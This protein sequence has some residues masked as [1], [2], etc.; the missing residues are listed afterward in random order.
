MH[1]TT[2]KKLLSMLTVFTMVFYDRH[3]TA[4]AG[5]GSYRRN[6]NF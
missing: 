2:L 1:S 6:C 3:G 5:K 4:Y